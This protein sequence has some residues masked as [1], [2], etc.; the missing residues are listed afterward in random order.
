MVG[1]LNEATKTKRKE[2]L[3]GA[4]E[5]PQGRNEQGQNNNC[6]YLDL[7]IFCTSVAD[8]GNLNSNYVS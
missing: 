2:R 7:K 6:L 5:G 1:N 3:E 4:V 8:Y